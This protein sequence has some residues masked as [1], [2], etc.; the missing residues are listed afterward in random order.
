MQTI[1]ESAAECSTVIS[2]AARA[3]GHLNLILD[4]LPMKWGLSPKTGLNN[5]EMATKE[6]EQATEGLQETSGPKEQ[7]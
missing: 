5:L 6:G 3:P 7:T 2:E 4:I 1:K